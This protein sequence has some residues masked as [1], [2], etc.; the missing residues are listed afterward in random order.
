MASLIRRENSTSARSLKRAALSSSQWC[1]LS[2]MQSEELR[3]ARFAKLLMPGLLPSL[4]WCFW[5][6]FLPRI[7]IAQSFMHRFSSQLLAERIYSWEWGDPA[8]TKSLGKRWEAPWGAALVS[9]QTNSKWNS[10]VQHRAT[11]WGLLRLTIVFVRGGTSRHVP[12]F[13]IFIFMLFQWCQRK[14]WK[15]TL[16]CAPCRAKVLQACLLAWHA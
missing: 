2:L 7:E 15:A 11:S 3:T 16:A 6:R 10:Y 4:V 9:I 8:F 5:L 13:M 14:N 1:S 12:C